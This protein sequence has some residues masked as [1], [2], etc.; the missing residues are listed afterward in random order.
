VQEKK[1]KFWV[2]ASIVVF[3]IGVFHY[4]INYF[5][6]YFERLLYKKA[7]KDAGVSV[8][9]LCVAGQ[10]FEY[11]E[12]GK[13]DT[14]LFIHGFQSDKAWWLSYLPPLIDKYHVVALDL[15]GHGGSS[16]YYSLKYDIQS[17]AKEVAKFV[18]KKEIK[19]FHLIGTSMGGGVSLAYSLIQPER[20]LSLSLINP[21]GVVH[22]EK[23]D[24]QKQL[25]EGRNLFLPDTLKDLDEFS[26]YLIGRCWDIN[27]LMKKCMLSRLIKLRPFYKKAFDDLS[28]STPLNNV[29][30]K[31]D[32]E[33]LI[34][35]ATDDRMIHP[36]SFNMF[37]EA[38]PK[39]KMIALEKAGH[40][41]VGEDL[42]LATK[43]V[44]EFIQE[45]S[46]R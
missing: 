12:A 29:L 13:G 15:P 45:K 35:A 26:V 44:E 19:K 32:I 22:S 40:V 7:F 3:I 39:I 11:F 8:K 2:L 24:F 16:S 21:L 28:K 5:P 17:L 31:I 6:P 30:H 37:V 43:H 38:M 20:V 42:I 36:N 34:I 46:A 33:T 9:K 18:E 23:S 1:R 41:L 25:D 27:Y 14:I 4:I 10:D